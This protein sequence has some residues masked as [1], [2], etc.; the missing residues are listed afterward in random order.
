[1]SYAAEVSRSQPGCFVFLLDQSGSMLDTF[2]TSGTTKAQGVA[3]AINRLLHELVLKCTKNEGVRDYYHLAVLGYGNSRVDAALGSQ[4]ELTPISQVA[5]I[6]LRIET[7]QRKVEDGAGGLVQETIRLPIWVDPASDGDTPM[8][9]ALDAA[10]EIVQRFV[11]A[12][13]GS[14][15]P[16]VINI[17]DGEATDGDPA[18]AADRLRALGTDDGTVLLFNCHI[19][20]TSGTPVVFAGSSEALVDEYSQ[21]LFRMSS[22]LPPAMVRTARAEGFSVADGARGFAFNADLSDLIRFL[23]IG[24]RPAGLR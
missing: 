16:I 24:T 20:S 7:L 5:L 22:R 14:Y 2:S 18:L 10:F 13:R 4:L 8:S 3:T 1:M 12:H 19:S 9:G 23:D 21:Q 11:A 17:T 6:P 15:P